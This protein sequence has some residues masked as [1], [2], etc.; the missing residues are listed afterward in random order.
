MN[1]PTP[2]TPPTLPFLFV[3]EYSNGHTYYQTPQDT[4]H[5]SPLKSAFY[6]IR[7][8]PIT[9]ES[10][11]VKFGLIR[12]RTSPIL[13]V[14][15]NLLTGLFTLNNTLIPLPSNAPRKRE[16]SLLQLIYERRNTLTLNPIGGQ[17]PHQSQ[18]T[19]FRI[20]WRC[21]T[22]WLALDLTAHPERIT[23]NGSHQ[24]A[25]LNPELQPT[26]IG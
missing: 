24:P 23:L 7:E 8:S 3:A 22:D 12:L 20:G 17:P 9:P 4:S 26:L 15:V 18:S 13:V 5:Q 11:L 10:L 25:H 19:I 2:P 1:F 14:T 16:L 21:E 6:D